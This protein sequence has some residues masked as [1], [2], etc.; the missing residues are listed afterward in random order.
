MFQWTYIPH[1]FTSAPD[2]GVWGASVP[3]QFILDMFS[4]SHCW[5]G[6]FREEKNLRAVSRIEPLFRPCP[7]RSLVTMLTEL[8]MSYHGRGTG[9]AELN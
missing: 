8:R 6:L 2:I 5:S 3:F 7:S 4:R 9:F 1:S